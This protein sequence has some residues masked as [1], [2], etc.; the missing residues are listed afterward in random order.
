MNKK[1]II[2]LT[3]EERTILQEV[4]SKGTA[5]AY[6]IKHANIF[7]KADANGPNWKDHQLADAFSTSLNTVG[8]LRQR[9]VEYGFETA[10]G[11]KKRA[12]PPRKKALDGRQEARLIALRCSAP[13]AGYAKWTLQLLA[14]KLVELQV[15][16][17]ISRETIRQTLK[18]MR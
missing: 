16:D 10:L 18:K 7:L 1:Y 5:A 8:N 6:K 14:D 2:R 13:P 17:N 3:D 12:T 4:I 11:R 15:V 9:F